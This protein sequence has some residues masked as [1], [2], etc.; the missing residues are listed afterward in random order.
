MAADDPGGDLFAGG[1]ELGA[2]MAA[3]DWSATP[4]GPVAGWPQSLRTCVRIVL[5]SRRPMFALSEF[6]S[7]NIRLR[8]SR[9]SASS[10]C[11]RR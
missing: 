5:T 1:G 2:R 10:V 3:L 11:A 9:R 7:E 8:K 6:D 4:L